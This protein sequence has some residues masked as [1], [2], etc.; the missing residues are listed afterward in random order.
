VVVKEF[1][2]TRTDEKTGKAT[3]LYK[4]SSDEGYK[5]R[6]VGT[7]EIYNTAIDVE[8]APYAYEEIIP[9]EKK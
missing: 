6:K 4:T 5:L 8:G 7:D 3:N 9:K 2:R 1:Y